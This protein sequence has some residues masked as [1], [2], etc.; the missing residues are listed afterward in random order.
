MYAESEGNP[1][2][3]NSG[4]CLK[5]IFPGAMHIVM[6]DMKW[7]TFGLRGGRIE[8]CVGRIGAV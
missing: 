1:I 4:W 7:T 5:R 3:M 8:G 2:S 6:S